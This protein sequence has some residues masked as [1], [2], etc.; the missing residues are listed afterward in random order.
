MNTIVSLAAAVL[1]AGSAARAQGLVPV[2]TPD[3]VYPAGQAGVATVVVNIVVDESGHVAEAAVVSRDPDTAPEPFARAALDA[4]RAFLFEPPLSEG[5]PTRVSLPVTLRFEPPAPSLPAPPSSPPV[6][7]EPEPSAE[8]VPDAGLVRVRARR[9]DATVGE[10][11][12]H[13]ALLQ[14]VPH[15]NASQ[16]L[17]SAPG[18]LLTN[19]GGEGH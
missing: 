13:G 5:R 11:H 9:P 19:H 18:I 10:V 4:A 3:L 6:P 14:D 17:T 15:R 7:A 16:M 1:L 8:V 2:R 12:L